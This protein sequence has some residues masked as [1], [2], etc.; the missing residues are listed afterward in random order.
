MFKSRG[1]PNMNNMVADALDASM[2]NLME[3]RELAVSAVDRPADSP[4]RVSI[5]EKLLRMYHNGLQYT[6]PAKR[7]EKDKYNAHYKL[8]GQSL[9]HSLYFPAIYHWFK[10]FGRQNV[11]VIPAES[12]RDP[13]DFGDGL[14]DTLYVNGK[15]TYRKGHTPSEQAGRLERNKVVVRPMRDRL[16]RIYK[17]MGLCSYDIVPVVDYHSAAGSQALIPKEHQLNATNAARLRDFF[18][19]FDQLLFDLVGGNFTY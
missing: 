14:S 3:M 15:K 9:L 1:E 2:G 18:Q 5:A 19:P 13:R 8:M 11:L 6:G 7:P 10:I 16:N 4:E 17:F 12:L